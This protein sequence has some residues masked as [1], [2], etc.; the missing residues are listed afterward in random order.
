MTIERPMFP[1]RAESVDSFSHQPGIG[2]PESENLTSES[3]RPADRLSRRNAIAILAV[4]SAA[5][6]VIGIPMAA[7]A[8]IDPVF[9]L[10]EIHRKTHIAHMSSLELQARF[11]RR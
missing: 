4:G 3:A 5:L 2:Q 8:A 1:P 7:A 9:D 6:P 10:I 11:E